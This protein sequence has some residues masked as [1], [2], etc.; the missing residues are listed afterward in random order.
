LL[1]LSVLLIGV[2]SRSHHGEDHLRP[3]EEQ[4]FVRRSEALE[5]SDEEE[6]L[7]QIEELDTMIKLA[8]NARSIKDDEDPDSM[9][10]EDEMIKVM[11][12]I[13][14][15]SA[16]NVEA[17]SEVLKTLPGDVQLEFLMNKFMMKDA[18][19][20]EEII[21]SKTGS[22]AKVKRSTYNRGSSH[23]E[24]EPEYSYYK[25]FS[26]AFSHAEPEPQPRYRRSPADHDHHDHH[27]H[28]DQAPEGEIFHV[29]T[30]MKTERG[31]KSILLQRSADIHGFSEELEASQGQGASGTSSEKKV[32]QRLVDMLG[33]TRKRR[34]SEDEDQK[35]SALPRK[36]PVAHVDLDF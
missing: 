2:S 33:K 14:L 29:D 36:Q 19:V 22:S 9:V 12:S 8:R 35:L 20:K 30:S 11:D 7:Q 17:V 10:A 32:V 21:N 31:P 16:E 1:L 15:T 23:A 13:D 18:K 34:S 25:Q 26:T 4:D 28:H 6:L 27:D 3:S 24:P 5:G